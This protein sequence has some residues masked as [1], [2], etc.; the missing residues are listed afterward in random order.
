MLD[1]DIYMILDTDYGSFK[2]AIED[3]YCNQV[4]YGLRWSIYTTL[5]EPLRCLELFLDDNRNTNN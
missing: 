1:I 5:G 3:N 4:D 2:E